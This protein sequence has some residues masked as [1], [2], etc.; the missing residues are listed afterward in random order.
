MGSST[1]GSPRR[2][3][4]TLWSRNPPLPPAMNAHALLSVTECQCSTCLAIYITLHQAQ[5]VRISLYS[6]TTWHI[7]HFPPVENS[8]HQA[9]LIIV[10]VFSAIPRCT[11]RGHVKIG[12]SLPYTWKPRLQFLHHA[13]ALGIP[14]IYA[15]VFCSHN[16]ETMI[17]LT[18]TLYDL[19]GQRFLQTMRLYLLNSD[20]QAQCMVTLSQCIMLPISRT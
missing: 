10:P 8:P 11:E 20:D 9:R 6:K 2:S 7:R 17:L 3:Q 4:H 18:K 13:T 16:K 1:A 14:R 5:G 12:R 15:T 19:L